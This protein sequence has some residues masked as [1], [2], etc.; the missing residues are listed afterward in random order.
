VVE[1][2]GRALFPGLV[3]VGVVE[4]EGRSVKEHGVIVGPLGLVGDSLTVFLIVATVKDLV[5]VADEPDLLSPV[6]DLDS[7]VGILLLASI[8]SEARAEGEG[9]TV[10]DGVLVVVTVR[11]FRVDLPLEA[12]TTAS[13]VP[14]SDNVLEC[15][16]D[17]L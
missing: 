1:E 5:L 7:P 4:H 6:V 13:L 3:A 16:G 15:V 9:A 2:T 11:V 12:S 17:H 14:A 10:G 8:T